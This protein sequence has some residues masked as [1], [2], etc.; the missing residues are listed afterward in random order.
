MERT[1]P[2]RILAVSIVL[3]I[4]MGGSQA[5][6]SALSPSDILRQQ[7]FA[8]Y[9][10]HG[11]TQPAASVTGTRLRFLKDRG[12]KAVYLDFS[13]YLGL[14]ELN[15]SKARQASLDR[16]NTGVR[17]LVAGASRLGLTVHAVGGG[18][19]WTTASRRYLGPKLI[20]LVAGYNATAPPAGR[21][22][23]VQFDIEPYLD[24]SFSKDTQ[25]ALLDYLE[26]LQGIVREYRRQGNRPANR[27]L[28]L[29]F[30][31]PFWFDGAEG[32]PSAVSFNGATKP[33]AYHLIDMLK[34]LPSAYIVVM[35]YRNFTSGEDG[36][37]A[38]AANEFAYARSV[39]ARC[40]LVV[41]Q[42]FGRVQ[43]AKVTFNVLGRR[44]FRR[45]AEQIAAVY[46]RFPQ[47]RGLS[48]NDL[49]SYAASKE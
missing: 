22:S 41:G 8:V 47:F 28:R 18:P 30:A 34:D 46:G 21:L 43:P 29:G 23:G 2:I 14:T 19:T 10:W 17:S 16:A 32:A 33:A 48:V 36:S 49:D 7:G 44:A 9:Q 4:A 38:H 35:S 26:T 27:N 13:G 1:K 42:E 45:A 25:S 24:P 31:I 11:V 20:R 40:G 37:I 15:E 5:A 39:A 12:F 6:G 3:S